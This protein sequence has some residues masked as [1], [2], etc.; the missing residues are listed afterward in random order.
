MVQTERKV[1]D[2][3]KRIP[4]IGIP[5]GLIRGVVYKC[6]GDKDEADYSLETDVADLYL[7]KVPRNLINGFRSMSNME[8][9][10]WIGRRSLDELLISCTLLS[11][12]VVYHWCIQINGIIYELTAPIKPRIHIGVISQSNN[13]YLYNSYHK[14]FS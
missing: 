9:G 3:C 2:I 10:I 5:Y 7:A 13:P 12:V 4:P 8:K 14:R 6:V 1:F 11:G